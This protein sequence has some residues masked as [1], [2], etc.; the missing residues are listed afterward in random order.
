MF[1]LIDKIIVTPII[2]ILFIIYHFVGDFGLAII[3]F[4][5][6]V[7]LITW[8]LMKKNLTQSKLMK[9]LQ[10]ELAEIK[11][12]CK[13]NRQLETIQTLD[14]YRRYNL[15]PFRSVLTVLIQLP[16]LIAL[17]SA[18][19]TMVIPRHDD[20]ISSRAY[21]VIAEL[22]TIKDLSDKQQKHLANPLE[23]PYDFHPKFLNTINLDIR[24]NFNDLAG[25]TIFIFCLAS[26]LFQYLIMKDQRPSR[27]NSRT[28]R[29]IFQEAANGKE[30]SQSEINSI[31]TSQM[32]LTMPIMIF[33]LNVNFPGALVFY[34]LVGNIIY[35]I[36]QKHIF[37][38]NQIEM[39]NIADKAI[40]KELK[41][42]KE[43]QLVKTK[44]PKNKTNITRISASS[45]QKRKK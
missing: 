25:V 42:A 32:S 3:F 2:N 5:I 36:Q 43:A 31:V 29:Q 41:D 21:P 22:S 6:L 10:P 16:I 19:N 20:N 11:K 9:K 17:F 14:L 24:A 34:Y 39:D 33:L 7:K 38:E 45:S 18:V 23:T 35:Y 13:G 1:W 15:K 4:T 27:K 8:P 12:N 40:L 37:K 30:A 26:A 28:L 44:T